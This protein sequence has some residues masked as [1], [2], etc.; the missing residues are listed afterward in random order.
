MTTNHPNCINFSTQWIEKL[1]QFA[2][3]EKAG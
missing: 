1:M 2:R 3:S